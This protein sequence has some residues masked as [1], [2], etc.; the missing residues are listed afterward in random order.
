VDKKSRWEIVTL[1]D[2]WPSGEE[3][4]DTLGFSSGKMSF[5][6]LNFLTGLLISI[7]SIL[8]F[9]FSI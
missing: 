9:V 6:A 8:Q 7:G 4:Q 5:N 1:R 3:R 2:E